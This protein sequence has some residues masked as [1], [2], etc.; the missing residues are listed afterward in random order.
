MTYQEMQSY[1][2][3]YSFAINYSQIRNICVKFGDKAEDAK[4]N[5]QNGEK[6]YKDSTSPTENEILPGI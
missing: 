1:L 4:K 6:T 3:E 5:D 2:E